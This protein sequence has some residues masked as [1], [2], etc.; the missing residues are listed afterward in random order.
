VQYLVIR[1][2]IISEA[3]AAASATAAAAAAAFMPG[4]LLR[5]AKIGLFAI[6]NDSRGCHRRHH[7]IRLWKICQKRDVNW[8]CTR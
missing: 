5:N 4:D 8:K 7:F 2:S 3:D 6:S 1:Q